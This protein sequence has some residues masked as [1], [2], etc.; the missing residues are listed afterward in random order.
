MTE[1]RLSGIGVTPL[2]GVGTVVWYAPDADLGEP[3]APET[4]DADAEI[5]RFESARDEAR[6]E[7]RAE[8]ERTAERVGEA[9][10]EVFDAHVQFLDD[11]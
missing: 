11:P 6:E 4:V 7:I 2:S 9:E 1:R 3:P 5:D 8:R 10:A